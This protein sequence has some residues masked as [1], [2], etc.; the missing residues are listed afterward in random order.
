MPESTATPL[1]KLVPFDH[2][3]GNGAIVSFVG[4]REYTVAAK[5]PS[6]HAS[7]QL[8]QFTFFS[9]PKFVIE[10]RNMVWR[11]SMPERI[12]L[13]GPL[14][15]LDEHT[16]PW[17]HRYFEYAPC[18]SQS[19]RKHLSLPAVAQ[20]CHEARD[21]YLRLVRERAAWIHP[22]NYTLR[23]NPRPQQT[24]F[25]PAVDVLCLDLIGHHENI[26]W[27]HDQRA[28]QVEL[29]VFAKHLRTFAFSFRGREDWY[30]RMDYFKYI[31]K[32]MT[33][34]TLWPQLET[35]MAYDKM[36]FV[37]PRP[38]NPVALVNVR[39]VER[40]R[41]FKEV[42]ENFSAPS[43][44]DPKVMKLLSSLLT[45][46]TRDRYLDLMRLD[47]VSMWAGALFL[48]LYPGTEADREFHLTNPVGWKQIL[49]AFTPFNLKDPWVRDVIIPLVPKVQMAV[50]FKLCEAPCHV[51]TNES[52]R[53]RDDRWEQG[54]RYDVC[55]MR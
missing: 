34:K 26:R 46:K 53:G 1:P 36:I 2:D 20:T 21:E 33:D 16:H 13:V 22:V 29:D 40:I 27:P 24:W 30:G 5:A 28:N 12:L 51:G 52:L 54:R 11:F 41:Q 8:D 10:L 35:F 23:P 3:K 17:C 50:A 9:H 48:D 47:I 38:G 31:V 43:H 4:G 42:Y 39:D 49:H 19:A 55:L 44:L 7:P 45:K 32:N 14:A 6:T 37:H 25:D 18:N 15:E